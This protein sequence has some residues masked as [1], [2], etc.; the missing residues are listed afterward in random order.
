MLL[1][2]MDGK[3]KK[4]GADR[5]YL[6]ECLRVGM[7]TPA[8]ASRRVLRRSSIFCSE[9]PRLC[10]SQKVGNEERTETE[11]WNSHFARYRP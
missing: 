7:S 9:A 6:L 8:A 1:L 5:R 11:E 3:N 10:E 4:I 2:S